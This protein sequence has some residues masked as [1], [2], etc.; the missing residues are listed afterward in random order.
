MKHCT[1]TNDN[2]ILID[3]LSIFD[4]IEKT[5]LDLLY[6][7]NFFKDNQINPGNGDVKKLY[8]HS[9]IETLCDEIIK[10]K[11]NHQ[12]VVIFPEK[13]QKKTEF[14][15]NEKFL[16]LFYS[17]NR[18]IIKLLPVPM[19]IM[20][21]PENFYDLKQWLTGTGEGRDVL[22]KIL[23]LVDKHKNG[24]SS[25]E[26]VKKFAEEYKLTFLSQ[27]YFNNLSNKYKLIT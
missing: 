23:S 15:D 12:I 9:V 27:N 26:K 24:T 7:Y 6:K 8:Y 18:K 3:F 16:K 19:Y 14:C 25:F 5:W 13:I 2:I 22:N 21:I 17:T 10:I 1:L 11:S 4:K 20:S